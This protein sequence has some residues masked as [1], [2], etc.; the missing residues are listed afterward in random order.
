LTY[1]IP[2]GL[3]G[4]AHRK[5]LYLYLYILIDDSMEVFIYGIKFH[6]K[7]KRAEEDIN[8]SRF[9]ISVL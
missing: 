1:W 6:F 4:P 5:K 3:S 8:F 2:K 7:M 9:R